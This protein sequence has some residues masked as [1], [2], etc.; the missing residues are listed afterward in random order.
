MKRTLLFG[1]LIGFITMM[2]S[3]SPAAFAGN[4][5][6]Q[7]FKWPSFLRIATPTT[8][9]ASFASVNGWGPILQSETGMNVRVVPEDSEIRRYI[10]F[11]LNKEF[12]LVSTSIAEVGL[13]IQG[14]SGYA[15]QEAAQQRAVWHHND[16]PWSF[17]VR[18]D[19][20]Y[21]TIFDLKQKGV[22][23]ALSSQSPPMMLAVQE[24]LPAFLGWT[25][26]EAAANWTF[27]PVGSYAEN[28]RAVTDGK[29]DVSYMTPISSITYEMEAHPL[30][31]RWLAMPADNQAGWDGYLK[32]RPTVI[33]NKI[34]F[35]VPSAIG[36]EAMTSPFIFWTRPDVDQETVYQLTKWLH[37]RFEQYKGVHA[38]NA[39]MSMTHTRKFLDRSP[40]PV[41]EGTI[42]YLREIGQWSEADDK[43]NQAQIELMDRWIAARNATLA[44]AKSKKVK[45]H[46]ENKEYLDILK[47][48]TEGLPVFKTRM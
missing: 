15:I 28:C 10:R 7:A 42:R 20:K 30:K 17:A 46:W 32:V 21:K 31:I 23:V 13:S 34:D 26:E 39:R 45:L 4:E 3:W 11:A 38:I 9:S 27:V 5:T 40:F 6:K 8:Q 44:E 19:S 12:E 29:A 43:W 35:G 14:E 37:E 47:K 1:W 18:G 16:T 36:V 41:A 24:A 22:R 48:H 2:L 25:K 33:P